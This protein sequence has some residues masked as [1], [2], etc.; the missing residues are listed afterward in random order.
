MSKDILEQYAL[1]KKE[2]SDIEKRIAESSRKIK[3]LEKE[4]ICDTVKGSREDF[5]YGRINVR[6]IAEDEIEK[7]WKR[8]RKYLERLQNFKEKLQDMIIKIEEFIQ[9]IPNSE[10]RMMIRYRFTDNLEWQEVSKKMGPGYTADACRQK[11]N[12]YLKRVI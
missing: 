10:V 1:V 6:G 11:V 8:T 9:Q 12:R 5:S 7:Q 3:Q 4:I 2:I